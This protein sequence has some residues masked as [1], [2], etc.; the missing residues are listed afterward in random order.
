VAGNDLAGFPNGRRPGDDVV[1]IELRV[2]MGALC[3]PIPVNGV[4]TNLG[5]RQPADAPVGNV[6]F[7]DGAPVSA[8]GLTA[9]GGGG[10]NSPIT[11][12][13]AI[14]GFANTTIEQDATAA[15]LSFTVR[16]ADSP[17]ESLLLDEIGLGG[18]RPASQLLICPGATGPRRGF[19]TGPRRGF[20]WW[21][22]RRRHL[23][24]PRL[25]GR[26][27]DGR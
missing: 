5:L 17:P 2:A 1:D 16:D 20:G 15:P 10:S 14:S 7:T 26:R 9:C 11:A 12:A 27:A 6:P 18:P 25:Q 3:Y 19:P 13:P 22:H 21:P 23:T 24:V 4:P 8:A